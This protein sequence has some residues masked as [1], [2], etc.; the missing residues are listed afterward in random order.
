MPLP[1]LPAMSSNNQSLRDRLIRNMD[2]VARQHKTREPLYD[3]QRARLAVGTAAKKLG[4][5]VEIVAP[6]KRI[7]PYHLHHAQEEM[8]VILEGSGTLRVAEE[9]LPL[10][11]GDVVF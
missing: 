9:M 3:S 11:Q 5:T 6:G 7:C 1:K 4:A 2:E 10:K 8:F